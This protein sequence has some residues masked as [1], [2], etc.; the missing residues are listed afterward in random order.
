VLLLLLLLTAADGSKAADAH[1]LM[2]SQV[3][4]LAVIDLTWQQYSDAARSPNDGST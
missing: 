1:V 4:S 3:A 2:P